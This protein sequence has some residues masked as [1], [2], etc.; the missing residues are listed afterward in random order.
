MRVAFFGSPEFAATALESL[1][2]HHEVCLVVTQPDKPVGRG[3]KL[4]S[5]P[6]ASAAKELGLPLAQPARLK[7]NSTFAEQLRA[8]QP[9]VAITA[10]YGKILPQ[11]LLET[12]QH[13][14][15]NIHASLLP[16]Y[17]GAA[18]IQWALING[19]TTTGITIMQTEAG[20]D[21]GPMRHVKQLDI[22]PQDT[23]LIL[24]DKLATLGAAAIL[25]ALNLLE[26]SELPSTP[27]DDRL[28]TYAPLLSKDDGQVRWHNSAGHIINRFRGVIAW[29]GSWTTFRDTPLKI[30]QFSAA[31]ASGEP[32]KIVAIDSG[33]TV[34]CGEKA[35][36]LSEV[37][38]ANRP[39]MSARD[40]INGY[41][42]KVGE[43]FG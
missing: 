43:H 35:V 18:P 32:G 14:F 30:H 20:L 34:T 36:T 10:A 24:F 8:L 5:P 25:E 22:A 3:L 21:T 39:R 1:S 37:Q 41:Q 13:G 33:V 6:A 19:E 7:G 42:V 29:P 31:E 28:A 26:K 12:P 16:K 40:W 9:E 23:A 4:S 11:T 2:Q 17:R 15:L 38:P 27:Q